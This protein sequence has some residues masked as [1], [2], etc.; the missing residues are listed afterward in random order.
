MFR[1]TA[2][3]C[4]LY[5]RVDIAV[6]TPLGTV[7]LAQPKAV[8]NTASRRTVS[9]TDVSDTGL[10]LGVVFYVWGCVFILNS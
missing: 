6:Q 5:S 2:L 3:G 8:S 1:D 7:F 4:V 9:D 10:G